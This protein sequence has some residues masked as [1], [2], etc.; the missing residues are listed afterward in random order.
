MKTE[1]ALNFLRIKKEDLIG[2]WEAQESDAS[3][4]TLSKRKGILLLT[5]KDLIFVAEIGLF[6]KKLKEIYRVP[7]SKIKSVVKLPLL[8]KNTVTI[9]C[10][11]TPEGAGILKRLISTRQLAFKLKDP[12]S[13][14]DK[15]KELN[16]SIK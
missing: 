4:D 16:P 8:F 6:S 5:K 14:L 1:E 9:R 15:L 11:T 12:K 3:E 2:K 7:V 13:L 10:N